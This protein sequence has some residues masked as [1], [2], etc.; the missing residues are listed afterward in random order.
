LK[1]LNSESNNQLK[2][3]NTIQEIIDLSESEV[4]DSVDFDLIETKILSVELNENSINT[5]LV[6]IISEYGYVSL[7]GVLNI[8]DKS[9]FSE[10]QEYPESK[11]FLS[12][13]FLGKLSL[14]DKFFR[15]I[16]VEKK[17]ILPKQNINI[18]IRNIQQE[19]V[20]K[21]P[22]VLNSNKSGEL[23]Q[24]DDD[25][26]KINLIYEL[27]KGIVEIEI[28]NNLYIFNGY[29]KE[30]TL[31]DIFYHEFFCSKYKN[32]QKKFLKTF[33]KV[34]IKHKTFLKEF[35]SQI[36]VKDFIIYSDDIIVEKIKKLYLLLNKLNRLSIIDLILEC[37]NE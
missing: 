29:F 17:N 6:K 25:K 21:L 14:F 13:L 27:N 24:M 15:V 22:T 28:E 9:I 2:L 35:M 36:S 26:L 30:D 34:D 3:I 20:K 10:H 5:E 19:H 11:L 1:F 32:I 18:K 16:S 37:I 12:K 8:F 7:T 31:N 23:E 33:D 4:K